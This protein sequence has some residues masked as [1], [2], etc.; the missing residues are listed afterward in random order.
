MRLSR[1]TGIAFAS[2]DI[3]S[4]SFSRRAAVLAIRDGYDRL[5]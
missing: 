3:R 5:K 2:H 1:P 4:R